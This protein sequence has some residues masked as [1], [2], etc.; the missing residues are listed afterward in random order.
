VRTVGQGIAAAGFQRLVLFNAHGGQIGLLE[1]AARELRVLEPRLAVLPVFL[2]RGA[3][4]LGDL[5]PE[6]ERSEGL[7]AGLAETSL[8]LF[9]EPATVGAL[10]AADGPGAAQAPP[11]G[12]SLEGACPCA[13]LTDE[14]SESGVIGDPGGA[15]TDLGRQLFQRLVDGWERRL[16]VLVR[17]DWPVP[18]TR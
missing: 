7:H 12:W 1:A 11:T 8:M 4:G 18:G 6:P 16:D 10:P 15:S 2:W 5:I 17:S 14:L 13:W 3:D 9:L